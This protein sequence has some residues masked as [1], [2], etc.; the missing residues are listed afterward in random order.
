MTVWSYTRNLMRHKYFVFIEA[1]KLGIPLLGLIH[2]ISKF[3][4]GEFLPYAAY[5]FGNPH[6]NSASVK[7]AF[8]I[9]WNHHQKRNMHHW[10]AWL[11]VRLDNLTAH[12]YNDSDEDLSMEICKCQKEQM[13]KRCVQSVDL[14]DQDRISCTEGKSEGYAS[15]TIGSTHKHTESAINS[16]IKRTI[17][18]VT[19]SQRKSKEKET[20]PSDTMRNTGVWCS[21]IMEGT[22]QDALAA[23]RVIMN[24]YASTISTGMGI[25]TERNLLTDSPESIRIDGQSK[26][27]T[28][29]SLE[30]CAT[31]ATHHSDSMDIVHIGHT[32]ILVNDNDGA[33]CI[34]CGKKFS[35]DIFGALPMPERYILEMVADWRGAGRAYGKNDTIAWYLNHHD[36]QIMHP[37][38]RARVE[39]LL[40]ITNRRKEGV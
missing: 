29:Q 6:S 35:Q 30:Y 9:A 2:D 20:T 1:W 15:N 10:Q 24:S 13:K 39:H 12:R 34:H 23:G 36:N 11:Y 16:I 31:T 40:G 33:R 7:E 32:K 17:A 27:T 8:D 5:N 4:P 28:L 26:I 3:S 25:S 14:S 18:R 38:T 21:H 19:R 22:R 37:D